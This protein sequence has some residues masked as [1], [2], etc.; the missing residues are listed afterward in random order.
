MAGSADASAN[1]GSLPGAR[2]A[3]P[4]Q[5]LGPA[6]TGARCAG[7]QLEVAIPI[8]ERQGFANPLTLFGSYHILDYNLFYANLRLNAQQRVL[9]YQAAAG[10]AP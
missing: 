6:L 7:G 8:G 9:A 2:P 4:L 1:L 3:T 10:R 5:P